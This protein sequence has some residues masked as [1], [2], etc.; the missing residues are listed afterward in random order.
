MRHGVAGRKFSRH[1][2]E[3][4]AMFDN[5]ATALLKHGQIKTTLEKAKDLRRVVEPLITLA[6]KG[7]LAARRQALATVKEPSVVTHLFATLAPLFANRKGGYTRVLKAGFRKG[8]A[9]A[10]AVIEL[11]EKPASSSAEAS[12]PAKAAKATKAPAKKVAA[13]EGDEAPAKA[14]KPA[15]PKAKK[16]KAE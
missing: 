8:D 4:K 5:L 6:K 16:A 10:M 12:A 7:D 13:A 2:A 15:A 11:T 9:A 3:R 1:S 14:K